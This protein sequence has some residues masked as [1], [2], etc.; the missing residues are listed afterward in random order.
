MGDGRAGVTRPSRSRVYGSIVQVLDGIT[1]QI[2]CVADAI[3]GQY[4]AYLDDVASPASRARI[5]RLARLP[6]ATIMEFTTRHHE[7]LPATPRAG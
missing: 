3:A 1:P 7:H 5:C 6:D 2:I 4:L